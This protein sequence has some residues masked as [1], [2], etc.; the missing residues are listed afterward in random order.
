MLWVVF[1]DAGARL[2]GFIL[3]AYLARALGPSTYGLVTIGLGVLAYLSQI[4]GAGLQVLETRNVAMSGGLDSNRVGTVLSLR[5][6][7]AV[8]LSLATSLAV[9]YSDLPTDTKKIIASSTLILLPLAISLEWFFQGRERFGVLSVSKILVA[10]V[11]GV[12]VIFLVHDTE[13]GVAAILSL[14]GGTCVG[15]VLLLTVFRREEG[16]LNV[17]MDTAAWKS[18]IQKSI[19][20][21]VALLVAQS[22]VNLGPIVLGLR[23]GT[24]DA[25]M[26][27]AAMKVIVVVLLLDRVLNSLFLP[28][29]SRSRATRPGE[30][31]SLVT[32]VFKGTFLLVLPVAVC[33]AI[34]APIIIPFVFGDGYLEAVDHLRFLLFYVVL[35]LLNSVLMCS[36]IASGEESR[37]SRL[38]LIGS[39]ALAAL[40][41]AGAE[42][43]GPRGASL[44]VGL[45]ELVMF[46]LLLITTKSVVGLNLY[47]VVFRCTLSGAAMVLVMILANGWGPVAT[48][49]LALGIFVCSLTLLR[50]ITPAEIR[51][52]WRKFV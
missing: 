28:L 2:I 31:S 16:R 18:I 19:P 15:A 47:S 11:Y 23:F 50:T 4:S 9:F 40:V 45:G 7:L 27:A 35:T 8:L 46:V 24:S 21:T 12:F 13:D 39:L 44:G 32:L 51:S 1:G 14:A 20:V 3:T 49:L 36:M 38:L 34:L 5:L 33:C 48:V 41:V 29:I 10:I 52:L 26:F 17:T 37:Y 6:F 43:A 30:F 25:G 22:A 42:A